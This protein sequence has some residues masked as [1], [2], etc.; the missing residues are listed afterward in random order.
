MDPLIIAGQYL[1]F[2]AQIIGG[3]AWFVYI[4]IVVAVVALLVSRYVIDALRLNPFNRLVHG[5]MRPADAMLGN[6]RQSRFY[7]PLR[8]ALNFDPAVL[9]VLFATAIACYVVSLVIHYLLMLMSGLGRSL[10]AF[11]AGNLFSGARYAVG[12]ILLAVIF[13]LLS[14]M[15]LVFA[16]W[17]FG[18][19]R[20]ASYRALERIGPLLRIF[21][22][23]GAFAGWSFLILGIALSFAASAVQLI[24]LS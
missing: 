12:T 24:F 17:I 13:Y 11:G 3:L 21:E 10:T 20:R 18:L 15:L 23:G 6:M 5:V 2:A 7:Y 9:M 14:L 4:G 22:F 1:I 16:Y 19:F 8:R